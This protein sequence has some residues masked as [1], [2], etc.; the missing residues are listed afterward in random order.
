MLGS[1]MLAVHLLI[2]QTSQAEMGK[3]AE[4]EVASSRVFI[5]KSQQRAF[6]LGFEGINISAHH[7]SREGVRKGKPFRFLF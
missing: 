4:R 2:R 3:R 6:Q 7:C 5:S 1:Q